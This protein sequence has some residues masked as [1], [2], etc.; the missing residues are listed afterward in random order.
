MKFAIKKFL[1][2]VNKFT[3]NLQ[4]YKN[5]LKNSLIEAFIFCAIITGSNYL[6]L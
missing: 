4:L 6:L 1:V 2:N 3:K 5:I